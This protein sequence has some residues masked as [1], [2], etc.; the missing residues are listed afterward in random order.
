MRVVLAVAAIQVMVWLTGPSCAPTA[1]P[2]VATPGTSAPAAP[3]AVATTG[4]VV[5]TPV[6]R[7]AISSPSAA[8]PPGSGASV[9]PPT[10]GGQTDKLV[11]L[12]KQDLVQRVSGLSESE[13]AVVRT[14]QETWRDTSLGCPE[15]GRM[16]AQV[17]VDGYR[18]ILEAR[19][20][21][22]EYHTDASSQ[23]AYCR[24]P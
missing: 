14:S 13:I 12:A 7:P 3:T 5:P 11:Q 6:G 23:V 24:N 8:G 16:Y 20:Q 18:I 17:I 22:Y 10:G 4:A 19:G 15:P 1:Q 2:S 21:R 9:G